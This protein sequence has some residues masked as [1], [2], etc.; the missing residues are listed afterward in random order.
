[1]SLPVNVLPRVK[2]ELVA[3]NVQKL[4]G[5]FSSAFCG[6]GLSILLGFDPLPS[7]KPLQTFW[8][9]NR[10]A[11]LI[12]LII[13]AAIGAGSFFITQRGKG[14]APVKNQFVR[15]LRQ[16]SESI[17]EIIIGFLAGL[18]LGVGSA[19]STIPLLALI[20]DHPPIGIGIGGLLLAILIIVPLIGGE[21][22]QPEHGPETPQAR[23]RIFFASM[24][25]FI[26]LAL[27]FV[28]FGLV[29]IR[30]AWCPTTICPAPQLIVVTNPNGVNDGIMEAFF[31]AQQSDTF[32][33]TQDPSLYAF[34]NL[35]NS[36]GAV[37]L[38]KTQ[39]PYRAVIGIHSL[40]RNTRYGLII[41]G[42]DI[43]IDHATAITSPTKVFLQGG[44]LTYN[45]SIFS[46]TY[47]GEIAPVTLPTDAPQTT[48]TLE[49]GG[50]DELAVQVM[51]HQ[52]VALQFHLQVRYH[53]IVG[54]ALSRTLVVPH[55]FM[56]DF[57][58]AAQWRP[59]IF[60]G[61][62]MIPQP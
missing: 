61:G 29:T 53:E 58:G 62:K 49:V 60:S 15:I 41:D 35:P 2:V 17:V 24:T 46:F 23:T 27:L 34:N 48:L 25:S 12:I 56:V 19:P 14:I 26:S 44:D 10:V 50:S 32:V 43:V 13:I 8:V 7:I 16:L 42:V 33:M 59:Y 36:V 39:A 31:L 51:A 52:A 37:E 9:D 38:E 4:L 57:I 6:M 55:E 22:E 45:H 11:T 54:I 1:M 5:K 20:R 21:E 40:Q 30:P 28:L 18:L 3:L 47:G